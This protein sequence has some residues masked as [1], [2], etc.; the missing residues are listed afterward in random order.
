MQTILIS[1]LVALGVAFILGV[2]L[3]I[4]K[5]VFYVEVDPK[6]EQ[7]RSVL[8]GANCGACGFPGC[9][10]FANAA[11]KGEAPSNGCTAGGSE[12]A[13]KVA[14]ILGVDASSSV[15]NKAM[16]L[17]QGCYSVS[18]PKGSY[19]GLKTCT[20]AKLSINGTKSCDWGCIGFGDCAKNC[21]FNAISLT[22]DG[23]VKIDPAK[24]VGCGICVGV[25][26]QKIIKLF[27][28]NLKGSLA[29]CNCR[30]PKKQV[31]MKNCKKGCIKCGKCEKSCEPQALK[32]VDGIPQID[33]S[34]CD[35]CGKCA[36]GCPTKVLTIVNGV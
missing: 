36:E 3:G 18:K 28:E 30:N 12:V 22:D 9:D 26:P 32:L 1:G 19:V 33:Y 2:L 15:P 21:P 23:L 14:S 35:A 27:P 13:K 11:A 29:L 4:F 17:C 31:I 10:G 25:C 8:P 7:V 16:L 5:Q 24:C 34:L 6:V 20:A